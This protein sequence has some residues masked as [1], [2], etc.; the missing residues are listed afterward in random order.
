MKILVAG[1][2]GYI[3]TRLCNDLANEGHNVVAVDTFWFGDYLNNKVTK[4]K[5]NLMDLTEDKLSDFDAVVFMA[6]LSNDP[7]AD[8]SPRLN[9][10]ENAAAP[11]YL[12]YIS[13]KAGVKRFVYASSCSVYGFT[14]NKS[15]TEDSDPNP[16]Y[17]Y[18]IS[19]LQTEYSIIKMEDENFR[20][21]SLRKGTVGGW[22]PRMR[23]DL[24]VNTMTKFALS[25]GKIVVHNP[26][27]WRP[28]VDVRDVV[29]AYKKSIFSDLSVSGIFNI[30]NEN[31]TIGQLSYDIRDVLKERGY[32]IDIE[33]QNRPDVRNYLASNKKAKQFLNFNPVYSPKDSVIEIFENINVESINFNEEKYYN[34]MTFKG[35]VGDA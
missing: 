20:P 25:Q 35:L 3:G 7:M 12:A 19:K 22:S 11:S 8:F 2:A 16:Q 31:Y 9:F 26:E 32:E 23:F 14:D 34:I 29:Q 6:G 28:L 27:L 15:M 17:P 13:K 5:A 4:I 10:I 18:G 1:G 30:C 21:I 33:M 24:V